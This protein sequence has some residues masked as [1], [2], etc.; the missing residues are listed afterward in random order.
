MSEHA[1][2]KHQSRFPFQVRPAHKK[3]TTF[4]LYSTIGF[5]KRGDTSN[6]VRVVNPDSVI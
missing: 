6:A 5:K 1:F 2:Y 3:A 4:G